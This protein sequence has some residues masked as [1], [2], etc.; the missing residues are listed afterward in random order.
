MGMYDTV[1][2]RCRKCG[3]T[4]EEQSKGGECTHI[5]YGER[6]APLSVLNGLGDRDKFIYCSHCSAKHKVRIKFKAAIDFVEND[7]EENWRNA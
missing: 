4:F 3:E 7:E 5:L 1:S 2:I 6:D